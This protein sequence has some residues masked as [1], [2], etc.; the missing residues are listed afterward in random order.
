MHALQ[1]RLQVDDEIGEAP[2]K[3]RL[4]RDQHIIMIRQTVRA[5]RVPHGLAQTPLDA[6]AHHG[7]AQFFCHREAETSLPVQ[8]AGRARLGFKRE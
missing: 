1:R 4:A 8:F 7:V 5:G 6:V 2:S 3:R